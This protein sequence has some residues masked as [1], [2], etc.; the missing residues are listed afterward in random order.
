MQRRITDDVLH[1]SRLRLGRYSIE[2]ENFGVNDLVDGT[3]GMFRAEAGARHIRLDYTPPTPPE[4]VR[5][6]AQRISQMLSNL[7][8]NAIKFTRLAA[9]RRIHVQA[10]VRPVADVAAGT[11][12]STAHTLVVSVSDTGIGMTSEEQA[13]LFLPYGQG[14][15]TSQ[16]TY[17]R[18]TMGLFI[19]KELLSLMGG[20]I[21]VESV[22]GKGSTFTVEVPVA[23]VVP[24]ESPTDIDADSIPETTTS[25]LATPLMP[26]TPSEASHSTPC[27]GQLPRTILG[28]CRTASVR[29]RRRNACQTGPRRHA[30]RDGLLR[31]QSLTTTTSTRPEPV[32]AT[33]K[34]LR[35]RHVSLSRC[36]TAQ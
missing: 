15:T 16:T 30:G 5:G 19:T 18:S 9:H 27:A 3:I 21:H 24:P 34:G 17:G 7:L 4:F 2:D 33:Q 28:T 8:S 23:V 12:G 20:S 14:T 32:N 35:W 36:S 6:D 13:N 26:V 10:A 29:A 11:T 25:S 1:I 31:L 22:S